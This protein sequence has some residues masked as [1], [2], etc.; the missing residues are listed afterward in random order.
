MLLVRMVGSIRVEWSVCGS[1]TGGDKA[2]QY[3][4]VLYGKSLRVR[5]I[6]RCVRIAQRKL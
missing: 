3:R 1:E 2:F 5:S 6:T 4:Y